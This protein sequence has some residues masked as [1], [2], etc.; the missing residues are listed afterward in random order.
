MIGNLTYDQVADIAN[1]LKDCVETLTNLVENK[2]SEELQNF[3][4]S[5]DRYVKYLETT[6]ELYKDADKAISELVNS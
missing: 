4:S 6:I 3:V 1:Q 2:S 5:V